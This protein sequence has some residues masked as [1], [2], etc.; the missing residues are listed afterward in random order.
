MV[1]H[2]NT[3]VDPWTVVIKSLNAMVAYGAM[4]APTG[5]NHVAVGTQLG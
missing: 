5:A 4:S 1:A 3:V 2:A